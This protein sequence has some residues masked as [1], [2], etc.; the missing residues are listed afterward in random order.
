MPGAS[1]GPGA[2]D[3][4]LTQTPPLN[5]EE[6]RAQRQQAEIG[7]GSMLDG[8]FAQ[9]AAHV[10]NL[11][12]GGQRLKLNLPGDEGLTSR[13]TITRSIDPADKVRSY[14]IDY[15]PDDRY[16]ESYLYTDG[17]RPGNESRVTASDPDN[18]MGDLASMLP[19]DHPR[20][21]D[22]SILHSS[23]HLIGGLAESK[24]SKS[25]GAKVVGR[26]LGRGALRLIGISGKS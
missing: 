1:F 9:N 3:P 11:R 17:G 6:L 22:F 12:D 4:G 19:L 10:K 5:P 23:K 21:S 16:A 14:A 20:N 8:A 2:Q 7:L 15:L 13:A 24:P 18:R 25:A 26:R